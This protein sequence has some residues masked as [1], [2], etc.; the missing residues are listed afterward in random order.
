MRIGAS[1]RV[2]RPMESTLAQFVRAGTGV[3]ANYRA[4]GRARSYRE[5][6]ARMGVVSEEADEAEHWLD[7]LNEALSPVPPEV[8]AA[9]TEARELNRIFTR[10]V[11]TAE[12]RLRELE[13]RRGNRRKGSGT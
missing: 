13:A 3:S 12:A 4:S 7:V 11:T 10:A 2:P 1:W 5:F 8:S 6:A 9:L